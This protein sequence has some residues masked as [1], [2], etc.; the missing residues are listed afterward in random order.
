VTAQYYN[1]K[2]YN[3][4]SNHMNFIMPVVR[5]IDD[6]PLCAAVENGDYA[7]VKRWLEGGLTMKGLVGFVT[8]TTK[9]FC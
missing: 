3:Y 2:N 8:L 9:V 1:S 7:A 6:A 4:H 5:W